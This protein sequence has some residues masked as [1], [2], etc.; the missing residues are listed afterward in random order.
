Q[1][2]KDAAVFFQSP[3]E[4]SKQC[5]S[6]A[7]ERELFESDPRLSTDLHAGQPE[8]GGVMQVLRS[9]FVEHRRATVVV[10]AS[11]EQ[12]YE[13]RPQRGPSNGVTERHPRP[14]LDAVH[15]ERLATIVEEQRLVFEVDEIR[16]RRVLRG[17]DAAGVL[18]ILFGWRLHFG[19]AGP[20]GRPARK[21]T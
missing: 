11:D 15:D 12:P 3:H 4:L 16:E 2:T 10:A 21:R 17:D 18:Q 19:G 1:D 6:W 14:S 20:G 5:P 7:V 13:D 8:I 9:D